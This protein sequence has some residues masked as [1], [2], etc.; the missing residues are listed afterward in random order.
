M[1]T[2]KLVSDELAGDILGGLTAM[3]IALPSA[4]A[5]AIILFFPLGPEYI[6][7]AAVAGIVGTVILGL[8]APIFGGTPR[9][10]TAPCAPAAAVVAIF[11][12]ELIK[13][14]SVPHQ[15]I[16]FYAATL[17]FLSG[18]LQ[19]LSGCFAL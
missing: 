10:I 4:I 7:K 17:A 1:S 2:K 12:T 3:L 8:I 11:I 9:L 5:F 13:D 14:G 15:A 18:A 19:F 16:P 6:G